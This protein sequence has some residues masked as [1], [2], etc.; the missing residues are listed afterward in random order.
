M[1]VD[2][3]LHK[4]LGK[5]PRKPKEFRA[6]KR[7]KPAVR[8]FRDGSERLSA[9][10]WR[11]RRVECWERDGKHCV[12]CNKALPD[13]RQAEIDHIRKR[14]LRGG[15]QLSNL[16]TLCGGPF[17]CHAKRHRKEEGL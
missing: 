6:K 14:S 5:M 4:K 15:D 8:V 3:T 16:R 9:G 12:E 13:I 2:I 7:V 10:E 11:R 17:G 1:T